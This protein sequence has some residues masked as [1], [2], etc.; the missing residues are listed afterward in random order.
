MSILWII[1]GPIPFS[2]VKYLDKSNVKMFPRGYCILLRSVAINCTN[3]EEIEKITSE[4]NGFPKKFYPDYPKLL[5]ENG[6]EEQK[7][8]MI[9][10]IEKKRQLLIPRYL[11]DRQPNEEEE[12]I[13]DY[14]FVNYRNDG[15]TCYAFYKFINDAT[16]YI[17][18]GCFKK[19]NKFY[20]D[21]DTII[22]DKLILIPEEID[23][24]NKENNYIDKCDC[25][26]CF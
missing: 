19:D 18:I 26:E 16:Q 24:Y 22:Y 15:C 11:F 23:Q 9:I 7:N 20:S 8:E 21:F 12:L 5:F 17:K 4:L 2:L 10:S 25:D 1:A 13:F 14:R 3:S 6:T